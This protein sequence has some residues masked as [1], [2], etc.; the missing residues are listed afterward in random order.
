MYKFNMQ[1]QREFDSTHPTSPRHAFKRAHRS[2]KLAALY[3]LSISFAFAT[4]L[5]TAACSKFTPGG[6]LRGAE[7][8]GTARGAAQTTREGYT[9]EVSASTVK[10]NSVRRFFAGTED[11]PA[12]GLY[13]VVQHGGRELQ[14]MVHPNTNPI[15]SDSIF[16]EKE[17]DVYIMQGICG[18]IYCAKA[19]VLIEAQK[20]NSNSRYQTVEL[21]DFDKSTS[22]PE[23]RRE[24]SNFAGVTSAF[25]Q[26]TRKTIP[27]PYAG[28]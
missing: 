8:N 22:T 6:T 2:W 19:A 12:W 4:V 11:E 16:L 18:D 5:S 17:N 23:Q 27:D 14:M 9:G 26:L 21:W 24:T 25:E 28:Y 15:Q 13:A 7:A 10:V 20:K 1:P 3:S